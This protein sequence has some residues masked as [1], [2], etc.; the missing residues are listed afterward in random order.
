MISQAGAEAY[1]RERTMN[2]SLKRG[3]FLRKPGLEFLE[4]E[5]RAKNP[6]KYATVGDSLEWL[7]IPADESAIIRNSKGG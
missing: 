5:L 2:S 3:F 6:P 4:V 7:R 1:E